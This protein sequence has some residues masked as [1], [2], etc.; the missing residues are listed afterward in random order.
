MILLIYS[1]VCC[2][3]LVGH[4]QDLFKNLKQEYFTFYTFFEYS[5]FAF[6]LWY[7]IKQKKFKFLI[8]LF[9]LFFLAF[10][11][12]YLLAAKKQR[13]DSA[14]IGIEAILL[15]I[16]IFYFFYESSKNIIDNYIYNHYCFW[17]AVGIMLYL[18]ASF[19]FFISF[20]QLDKA[21][22]KVFGNLTYVA[23]ILKNIFFA[24][25]VIIYSRKPMETI[26]PKSIP[27]LDM[28]F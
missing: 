22:I 25:A 7:N 10:Q 17:I 18:G 2:F 15:F 27:Y 11:L 6:L 13:L 26:K 21:Q 28:S 14:P 9:S 19:F 1:V 5:V 3:L 23:E 4:E 20:N 8:L 16:Y 12:T 24:I